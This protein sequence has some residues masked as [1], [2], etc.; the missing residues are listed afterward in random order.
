MMLT[1]VRMRPVLAPAAKPDELERFCRSMQLVTHRDLDGTATTVLRAILEEAPDQ[2]VG[3]SQLAE[4]TR[5]KRVTIIHHLRRLEQA[6][7]V[8]H[9]D[10]KYRLSIAGF[11]DMVRRIRA[12]TEAL[13]EEAEE[14]AQQLDREYELT[15][16][17]KP[18]QRLEFSYQRT[19]ASP[20]LPPVA[21]ARPAPKRRGA[22]IAK[23]KTARKNDSHS[24][25]K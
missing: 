2:P 8:E 11:G 4:R 3:S 22:K 19:R 15:S 23:S 17:L 21:T 6:G 7:L 20:G 1:V 10:H 18:G 5:I 25:L 9:T 24:R 13:L 16:A 14:L 12:D